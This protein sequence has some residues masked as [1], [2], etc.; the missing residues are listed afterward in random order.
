MRELDD[1]ALRGARLVVDERHAALAEAGELVG[2]SGDD[3]VEIGEVLAGRAPGRRDRSDR[4]V[5]KSVGNAVQD[6]VVAARVY[7]L[8]V[9]RGLGEEVRFP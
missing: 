2:R 7:E 1:D 5:F 3:V 6:L 8:A 9:Q 4:T